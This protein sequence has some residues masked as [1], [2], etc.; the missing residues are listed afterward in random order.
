MPGTIKPPPPKTKK[1]HQTKKG[2]DI[3]CTRKSSSNTGNWR[4]TYCFKLI[5]FKQVA[6]EPISDAVFCINYSQLIPQPMQQ[7]PPNPSSAT[8]IKKVA[9]RKRRGGGGVGEQGEK[10]KT[11]FPFF[12]LCTNWTS[13]SGSSNRLQKF[14]NRLPVRHAGNGSFDLNT[15]RSSC[16]SKFQAV[17]L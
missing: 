10:R 16:S 6:T 2:A 17:F 9:P 12:P 7:S 13:K 8:P 11:P 14:Q 1:K 4:E 15:K 5:S 3:P